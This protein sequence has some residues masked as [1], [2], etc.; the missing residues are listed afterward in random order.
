M[1][2]GSAV[3][4]EGLKKDYGAIQA[5]RGVDLNIA[6]GQIYG[7]LGPNGAGKT[8]LIRSLIGSTKASAGRIS[9]LGMDPVQE[10]RR[11]REH[12]GYMPQRPALYDDLSPREN[13]RFFGLAHKSHELKRFTEETIAFVGLSER[14]RDPLHKLSGGMKQ[15]VS[16]ACALV[17]QPQMLFLDE[18]TS[19]IDPQ[20]RE[21]FWLHFK[22]LAAQG[23]TILVS[24]HQM[25]EALYCDRLAV[26]QQ[27]LVLA[28]DDPRQLLWQGQA[29]ITIEHA[30]QVEHMQAANYPAELPSMLRRYGLDPEVSRIQVEEATLE[31]VILDLIH[32]QSAGQGEEA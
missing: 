27:G 28:E 12:I 17:N 23:V 31:Q 32:R 22:E 16:L 29:R 26:L 2:E 4:V 25:D 24:T 19:G 14:A 3:T 5:L 6:R 9:V 30:G 15:R 21:A 11:L 7:L 18:P 1:E 10:K 8:T 20:L 13:I